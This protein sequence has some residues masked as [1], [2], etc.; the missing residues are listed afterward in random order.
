[1]KK[2]I[3]IM[4]AVVVIAAALTFLAA[5][6]PYQWHGVD[7]TV[8]EKFAAAAGRP[9][10]PPLINTDQGDLLLF[11]FLIAG[12]AG[13]FVAGYCFREMFPPKKKG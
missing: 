13:G 6:L 10:S 3:L 11:F 5:R 4:S 8:V 12:T 2:T 9:A 7:E 1:M